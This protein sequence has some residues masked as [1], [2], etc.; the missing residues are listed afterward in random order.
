MLLVVL[1]ACSLAEA[2]QYRWAGL[3]LNFNDGSNWNTGIL[4]INTSTLDMRSS[5]P[6]AS[7]IDIGVYQTGRITLPSNCKLKLSKT[8]STVFR[9]KKDSSK[10]IA[11]F[12]GPRQAQGFNF[13]CAYNWEVEDAEFK[14]TPASTGPCVNDVVALTPSTQ[15]YYF[16]TLDTDADIYL[17]G[18][19]L[20]GR[21]ITSTNITSQLPA[22]QFAKIATRLSFPQST[23]ECASLNTEGQCK[24]L[25]T[26]P[27][28]TTTITTTTEA[29]TTPTPTTTTAI[30]T[31]TT[32]ITPTTTTQT[33]TITTTEATTTTTTEATTTT[34]PTTTTAITTTT[35]EATAS[36]APTSTDAV[37]LTSSTT[38]ISV[39][40]TLG[41]GI[42]GSSEDKNDALT[43]VPIVAGTIGGLVL[44]LLLLLLL[45]KRSQQ[46]KATPQPADD[47]LQTSFN[48][49]IFTLPSADEAEVTLPEYTPADCDPPS[50]P[51]S[52]LPFG[53][54]S[55]PR[56][57]LPPIA[58][59]DATY[60]NDAV[61]GETVLPTLMRFD[62]WRQSDG[63][64]DHQAEA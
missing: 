41:K 31:T 48:N 1:I 27:L 61:F 26:C 39:S 28:T 32:T 54:K 14:F 58:A 38:T 5:T 46:R 45:R 30:T 59:P 62:D 2:A 37:T 53:Y 51:P 20:D 21:S 52:T 23:S 11:R 6:Y 57:K 40:S 25:D 4:P 49:P 9:L 44:V 3:T 18:L 35:T 15:A 29:T 33:T 10:P 64:Y 12:L 16:Q 56:F 60:D 34:A 63:D 24:C 17:G 55:H 13:G 7:N 8:G 22:Y 36:P 19:K 43:M 47:D 42:A 50:T